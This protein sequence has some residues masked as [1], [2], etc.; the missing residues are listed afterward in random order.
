MRTTKK[1]EIR[2]YTKQNFKIIC[3]FHKNE[4]L[5]IKNYK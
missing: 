4:N 5:H 3:N 1:I 2:G